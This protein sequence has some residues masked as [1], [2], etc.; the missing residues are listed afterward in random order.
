MRWIRNGIHTSDEKLMLMVTM[1]GCRILFD[2]MQKLS[3]V[4]TPFHKDLRI[5]KIYHYEC[6]WPAAQKQ[7]YMI[8]VYKVRAASVVTELTFAKKEC[9]VR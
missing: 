6:P 7:I 1:T 4:I 9:D 8:N 5:P 2:H 3:K